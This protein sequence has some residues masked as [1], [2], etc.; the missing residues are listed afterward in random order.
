MVITII[1]ACVTSQFEAHV[2]AVVGLPMPKDFTKF[3]TTNTNAIMLNVLG[4]DTANKE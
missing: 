1:D 4:D 2:R 3:S